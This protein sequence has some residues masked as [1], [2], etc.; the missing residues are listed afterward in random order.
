MKKNIN[1]LSLVAPEMLGGLHAGSEMRARILSAKQSAPASFVL[2]R[3][4][5]IL[6]A[7]TLMIVSVSSLLRNGATSPSEDTVPLEMRAAGDNQTPTD[8]PLRADVPG[9]SLSIT[10]GKPSAFSSLFAGKSGNFPLVGYNGCVYRLLASGSVSSSSLGDSLGVPTHVDDPALADPSAWYGVLSNAADADTEAYTI[11]GISSST[12]IAASID[13]QWRIFQRFSDGDHGANG[14]S[15]STVLAI[16]G[17]VASLDLSGVG[18]VIDPTTVSTLVDTLLDNAVFTGNNV[19]GGKQALNITLTNGLTF[20]LFV[21]KTTF[22]ACG[23]W[24]CPEFIDAFEAIFASTE[25]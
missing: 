14:E 19:T 11:V 2:R 20:Q 9:G 5:P 8:S 3:T 15:L 25:G 1:D 7:V 21:S 4:V 10:D 24:D 16:R 12:A 13:G 17:N 18:K 22:S 23:S 6:A